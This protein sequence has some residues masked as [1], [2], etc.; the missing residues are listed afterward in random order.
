MVDTKEFCK[1]LKVLKAGCKPQLKSENV[2]FGLREVEPSVW[3]GFA[4]IASVVRLSHTWRFTRFTHWRC[5]LRER[6]QSFH[7]VVDRIV[8]VKTATTRSHG[9]SLLNCL[10]KTINNSIPSPS[11][12]YIILRP[13]HYTCTCNMF[14]CTVPHSCTSSTCTCT[15]I[16][17]CVPIY[18]II[19][20]SWYIFMC[21]L[22]D[23]HSSRNTIYLG[24]LHIEKQRRWMAQTS[25]SRRGPLLPALLSL[26]MFPAFLEQ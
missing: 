4:W 7:L 17:C 25:L 5:F 22:C 18:V 1:S 13:V 20:L 12:L 8:H 14:L 9:G 16:I 2:S 26:F 15:C 11:V 6:A 19:I 3:S 24:L 10:F 23:P 21:Q